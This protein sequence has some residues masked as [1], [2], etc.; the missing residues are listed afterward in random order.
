MKLGRTWENTK[1]DLKEGGGKGVEE[2]WLALVNTALNP[3][4]S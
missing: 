1:M 2:S 3:W 4:S